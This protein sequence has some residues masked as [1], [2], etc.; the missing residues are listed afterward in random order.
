MNPIDNS[1]LL[2]YD[3]NYDYGAFLPVLNYAYNSGAA[4]VTVTDASTFPAGHALKN[5]NVLIHDKFGGSVS[6]NII[7]AAGN[8]GA[9]SVAGLNVTK[10]LSITAVIITNKGWKADGSIHNIAAAGTLSYWNK[11]EIA[12][13]TLVADAAFAAPES[14]TL[15]EEAQGTVVAEWSAVAFATNYKVQRATNAG[16]SAGLTTVYQGPALTVSDD[17]VAAET[18]YYYRVQAL[19]NTV[20]FDGAFASDDITTAAEA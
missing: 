16:F 19:R 15:S 1:N 14:I 7:A 13:E 18:Q 3:K 12:V 5:I 4:T 11:G 17:T 20:G 10:G 8:T 6:G 2:G 9:V